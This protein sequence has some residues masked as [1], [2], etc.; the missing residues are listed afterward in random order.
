MFEIASI[1]DQNEY[2]NQRKLVFETLGEQL[3]DFGTDKLLE[4]RV[5]KDQFNSGKLRLIRHFYRLKLIPDLTLDKLK[6][7]SR[8]LIA[9]LEDSIENNHYNR[10]ARILMGF[11]DYPFE[12][13]SYDVNKKIY[14]SAVRTIV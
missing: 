6:D 11:A 4:W 3:K 9:N 13:I 12:C 5:N 10:V 1:Y 7:F 8:E 14:Q 2:H